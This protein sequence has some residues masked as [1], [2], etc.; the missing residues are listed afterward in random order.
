MTFPLVHYSTGV[1]MTTVV[2]MFKT[3]YD[4]YVHCPPTIIIKN[5][6]YSN[7]ILI[8]FSSKSEDISSSAFSFSF[9]KF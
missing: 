8:A 9:I 4:K 6:L 1:P 5:Y 2:L 7:R 3:V